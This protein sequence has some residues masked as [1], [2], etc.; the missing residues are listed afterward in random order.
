[1]VLLGIDPGASVRS[2]ISSQT[3]LSQ[4]DHSGNDS[5]GGTWTSSM[6]SSPMTGDRPSDEDIEIMF[7]QT[8]VR[9]L[10]NYWCSHY[11]PALIV[12]ALRSSRDLI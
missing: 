2:S 5:Q 10:I 1:M 6:L 11:A 3:F 12:L 4:S 8:A 7:A 9:N